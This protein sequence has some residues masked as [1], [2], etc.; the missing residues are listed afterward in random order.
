[1]RIEL[2]LW[3]KVFS[4]TWELTEKRI[5]S[6]YKG[7]CG[8]KTEKAF[9]GL[10]FFQAECYLHWQAAMTARSSKYGQ[11]ESKR[12]R[13]GQRRQTD[14]QGCDKLGHS[15][16]SGGLQTGPTQRTPVCIETHDN[17]C[18]EKYGNTGYWPRPTFARRPFK[19]RVRASPGVPE[20]EKSW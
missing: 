17:V 19:R 16:L 20:R 10:V 11:L 13:Q 12:V 15:A 5:G 18:V 6:A 3:T 8:K 2:Y 9:K 4:K 7:K 14:Y 1:M